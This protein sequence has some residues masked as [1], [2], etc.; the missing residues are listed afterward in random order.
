MSEYE[1]IRRVLSITDEYDDHDCI[2]WR[3]RDGEPVQ[4]IVGC[5]DVFY[6]ASADGDNLTPDNVDEFARAF[7]DA[8]AADA[9]FYGPM[10]FCARLR[11]MRPQGA[12][13]PRG[14]DGAPR[15]ALWALL[16]ACGP[17]REIDF[18]NPKAPGA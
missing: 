9:Q 10:L 8:K 7:A 6:W 16:D 13:Y 11:G 1:F 12:A 14:L 3:A 15:H 17:E 5:N 4:F 2:W 18:L